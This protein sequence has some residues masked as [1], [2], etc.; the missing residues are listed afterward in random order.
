MRRD[1]WC[2][3]SA[4]SGQLAKAANGLGHAPNAAVQD[5]LILGQNGIVIAQLQ[6]KVGDVLGQMH[7]PHGF[8]LCLRFP[9]VQG[10][11]IGSQHGFQFSHPRIPGL[12]QGLQRLAVTTQLAN[13]SSQYRGFGI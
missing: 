8:I 7:D 11:F 10:A 3:G 1:V 5:G 13:L 6:V 4:A 2:L 9:E 12:E